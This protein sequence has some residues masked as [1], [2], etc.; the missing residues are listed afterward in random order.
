MENSSC[1]FL[2]RNVV[3]VCS[4]VRVAVMSCVIIMEMTSVGVLTCKHQ[5][6]GVIHFQPLC[7]DK[8]N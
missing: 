1:S 2:V 7:K 4:C 8:G 3:D 6:D 5:T